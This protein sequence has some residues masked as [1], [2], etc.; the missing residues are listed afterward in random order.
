MR[1]LITAGP[2]WV[3]I[4]DVRVI[5]N[6]STGETGLL[7]ARAAAREGAKVTLILGPGEECCID[8]GIKVIR[9]RFFDEL[10]NAL[11][12]QLRSGK[13]DII[14][15]SAAVPDYR[16]KK[17]IARKLDSGIRAL[18]LKLVPTPKLIDLIKK[19]A[20]GSVLVGFKFEPGAGRAKLIKESSALFKRARA[21]LVV[22]NTLVNGSYRAYIVNKDGACRGPLSSKEKLAEALVKTLRR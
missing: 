19:N 22:A 6:I 20:P 7:I 1:I 10:K 17:K 14:V 16:P 15:H 2:A 21:D 11:L 13:Y 18:K 8:K 4:D 12:G 5:S 3:A 9:V